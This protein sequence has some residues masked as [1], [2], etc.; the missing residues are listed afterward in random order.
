MADIQVNAISSGRNTADAAIKASAGKVWGVTLEAA[1]ADSYVILYDNASAAS[2]TVLAKVM[3]DVSLEGSTSTKH[4]SLPGV[5]ASN[6][7]YADV[8]G[9]S[10]AYIVYYE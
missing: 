5:P 4:I 8:N 6:G 10:A 3:I 7:I 1:A 9:T 2:G